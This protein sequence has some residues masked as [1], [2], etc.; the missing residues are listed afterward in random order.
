MQHVDKAWFNNVTINW[1]QTQQPFFTHALEA[2]HIGQLTLMYFSG[3]AA[4]AHA[5]LKA[6]KLVN[7]SRFITNMDKKMLVKEKD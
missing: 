4:P 1:E 2:R 3:M 7:I 5:S 6:V